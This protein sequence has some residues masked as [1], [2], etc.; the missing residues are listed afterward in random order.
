MTN[1][2]FFKLTKSY[3][4]SLSA[5]RCN[6]VYLNVPNLDKDGQSRVLL[7]NA[8]PDLLLTQ[9]LLP[10]VNLH[11]ISENVGW[12]DKLKKLFLPADIGNTP[13]LL[14][15][16]AIIKAIGN[17]GENIDKIQSVMDNGGRIVFN[18]SGKAVDTDVIANETDAADDDDDTE[19][20]ATADEDEASVNETIMA[21]DYTGLDEK[22]ISGNGRVI[23]LAIFI[24]SNCVKLMDEIIFAIE[25]HDPDMGVFRFD[26]DDVLNAKNIHSIWHRLKS[27]DPDVMWKDNPD[28][29]GIW[30]KNEPL[31]LDG[32]DVPCI[33]EFLKKKLSGSPEKNGN[34]KLDFYVFSDTPGTVRNMSVFQ[35]D[36]ERI[37]SGRPYNLEV[38]VQKIK[39]KKD[40]DCGRWIRN[41]KE[42]YN[43]VEQ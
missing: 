35:S 31:I 42:V 18:I 43:R 21:V 23:P 33:L 22:H 4:S 2:D 16:K 41:N 28:T 15:A 30:R 20:S 34:P 25:S 19:S 27:Y 1:K 40:V 3:L 26:G 11:V 13:V 9:S 39:A 8:D 24:L 6:W 14:K 5:R 29:V 17:N 32:A 10:I 12:A 37:Y 36:M 38:M 7:T